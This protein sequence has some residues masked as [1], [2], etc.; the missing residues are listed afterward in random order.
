MDRLPLCFG[1]ELSPWPAIAGTHLAAPSP[2]RPFYSL[3]QEQHDESL[4]FQAGLSLFSLSNTLDFLPVKKLEARIISPKGWKVENAWIEVTQNGKTFSFFAED[5]KFDLE[6]E[7]LKL[8][9]GPARVTYRAA[10]VSPRKNVETEL[11]AESTLAT[12]LP[13]DR[14]P[15]GLLLLIP[16]IMILGLRAGLDWWWWRQKGDYRNLGLLLIIIAAALWGGTFLALW[17]LVG[18]EGA[19][20]LHFFHPALSF[21]LAVPIFGFLGSLLFVIDVFQTRM[22]V[23]LSPDQTEKQNLNTSMEF[24]LRLVLGPYVAIVMVLLFRDTFSFIR[25]SEELGAQATVAF[26]SGSLMVLVLQSLSE[27]GN[28]LL[29]EW[30]TSSR[31]TPSEIARELHLAMDEDLKLKE[32][33]LKYLGHL[34]RLTDD[35][36]VQMAKQSEL[37]EGLLFSLR[38]EARARRI[39]D[40]PLLAQHLHEQIGTAVWA[41]LQ[42]EGIK[43][44]WDLAARTPAEIDQ[45]AQRRNI[46]SGILT[47]Y[48]DDAKALAKTPLF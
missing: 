34:Q 41:K 17:L 40:V 36:I 2:L 29:G 18:D 44:V 10:G 4:N 23:A 13:F 3:R 31:Y 28:E 1:W 24:V 20:A 35:N 7:N 43:S 11:A 19:N 48:S 26:F 33:N 45:I 22:P 37:S 30:R 8:M 16:A 5:G 25:G 6:K 9:T 21:S 12:S 42:Q 15:Y 38:D 47:K 39:H 46:D 27:K 14:F 32:V